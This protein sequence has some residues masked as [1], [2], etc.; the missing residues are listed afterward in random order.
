MEDQQKETS[1]DI[2]NLYTAKTENERYT[3]L[4]LI[5]WITFVDVTLFSFVYCIN[6]M[7]L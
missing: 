7:L 4:I 5:L 3:N 6:W 2:G 1:F